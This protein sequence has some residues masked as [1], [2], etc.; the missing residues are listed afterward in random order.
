MRWRL[1]RAPEKARQPLGNPKTY[2]I[3]ILNDCG[4]AE[5]ARAAQVKGAENRPDGGF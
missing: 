1:K 2:S 5:I 4:A 3:N